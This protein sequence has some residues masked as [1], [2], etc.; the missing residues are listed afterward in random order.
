MPRI[1]THGCTLMARQMFVSQDSRSWMSQ[2]MDLKSTSNCGMAGGA[3]AAV[4]RLCLQ[5]CLCLCLCG[6][7]YAYVTM[8]LSSL[9]V[10]HA[11]SLLSLPFVSVSVSSCVSAYVC[12]SL[13]QAHFSLQPAR[14][15]RGAGALKPLQLL[16]PGHVI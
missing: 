14:C 13:R 9:F 10:F 7:C 1:K 11:V 15:G 2:H 3:R 4:S 6:W 8:S 5:L 12:C 16:T